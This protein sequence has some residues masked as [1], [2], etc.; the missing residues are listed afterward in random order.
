MGITINH[1]EIFFSWCTLL[2]G[3]V[4]KKHTHG[5]DDGWHK[6]WFCKH[7]RIFFT[8]DDVFLW[9]LCPKWGICGAVSA[10]QLG[11]G[12]AQ[13]PSAKGTSAF[14]R[15]SCEA[16]TAP[17]TPHAFYIYHMICHEFVCFCD[18]SD[19]RS[20]QLSELEKES[21]GRSWV[22]WVLGSY[23]IDSESYNHL[24]T[25]RNYLC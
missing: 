14:P 11:G 24:C 7:G 23:L 2:G 5:R 18:D 9:Y 3:S 10:E 21:W 22:C 13:K 6:F 12:K 20:L 17:Q 8:Q 25:S 16:D 1:R 15:P 4:Q 19:S